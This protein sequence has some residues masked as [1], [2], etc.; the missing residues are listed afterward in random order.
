[1]RNPWDTTSYSSDWNKD[2]P[3]WTSETVAQVPY[4]IDPRTSA[5]QGVFAVPMYKLINGLCFD[6]VQ[7]G[8]Y[9]AKEGYYNARYDADDM[10]GSTQDYYRVFMPAQSGDLYFTV[11]SYPLGT[12]PESCTPGS[13]TSGGATTAVNTPLVRLEVFDSASGFSS[14]L[15]ALF[16]AEQFPRSILISEFQYSAGTTLTARVEYTWFGSPA[17]DYTITVYSKQSLEVVD[18]DGYT[19]VVNMDGSSPS[20]FT[21]ST[22][23]GMDNA[24]YTSSTFKIA[25]TSAVARIGKKPIEDYVV[26]S[27]LDC[28]MQAPTIGDFFMLIYYNW[29]VI[30]VWFHVIE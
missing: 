21:A 17:P 4:G 19:R 24:G 10:A 26:Q 9:R 13:I 18:G 29:W 3:R 5:D 14:P 7:I 22:Y 11:E 12:V 23:S 15:G 25:A 20:G 8:H 2:D 27:L 1:M 30:F 16:Y 6:G 28:A